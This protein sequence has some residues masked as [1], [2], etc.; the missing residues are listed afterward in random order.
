MFVWRPTTS[1][2]SSFSVRS[3]NDRRKPKNMMM[4]S[5]MLFGKVRRRGKW[6]KSVRVALRRSSSEENHTRASKEARNNNKSSV[7][8]EN[9]TSG[10]FLVVKYS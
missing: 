9:S 4:M 7:S 8:P 10:V 5:G 2:A 3:A 6:A 1:V